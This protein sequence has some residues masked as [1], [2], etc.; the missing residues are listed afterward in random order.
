MVTIFLQLVKSMGIVFRRSRA[1][2]SAVRGPNTKFELIQVSIP[3]RKTHTV[4]FSCLVYL[5]FFGSSCFINKIVTNYRFVTNFS[6][7]SINIITFTL[8]EKIGKKF[9]Q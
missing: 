8:H 9:N 7:T 4:T 6:V 3:K 2:N 5:F 1:A